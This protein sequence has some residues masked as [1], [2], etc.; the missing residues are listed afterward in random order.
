MTW[1]EY[2]Q[3]ASMGFGLGFTIGVCTLFVHLVRRS[4]SSMCRSYDS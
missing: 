2:V 3:M 4:V 1:G